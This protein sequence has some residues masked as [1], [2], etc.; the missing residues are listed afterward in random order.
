[1]PSLF[2]KSAAGACCFNVDKE[3]NPLGANKQSKKTVVPKRCP[4]FYIK[5]A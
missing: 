4:E 3:N 1:M 2:L 5:I